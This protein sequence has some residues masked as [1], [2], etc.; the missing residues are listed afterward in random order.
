MPQLHTTQSAPLDYCPPPETEEPID[1]PQFYPTKYRIPWTP[2]ALLKK[3]KECR[4]ALG[5]ELQAQTALIK[6][7]ICQRRGRTTDQQCQLHA[8]LEVM[9]QADDRLS[10]D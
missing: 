9:R 5:A 8:E 2:T 10:R 4:H 6:E 1:E 3:T 7:A